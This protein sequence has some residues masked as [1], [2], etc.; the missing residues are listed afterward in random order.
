MEGVGR[1]EYSLQITSCNTVREIGKGSF[2]SV[3]LALHPDGSFMAVKTVK[4]EKVCDNAS[5]EVKDF[6]KE[7]GIM[8]I[9]RHKNIVRYLGSSFVENDNEFVLMIFQEYVTGGSASAL[10]RQLQQQRKLSGNDGGAF[11]YGDF[12]EEVN[13]LPYDPLR[14]FSRHITEGLVYLHS[15]NIAHRDLKGDNVLISYDT[16]IAK[17]AD[18]GAA[19]FLQSTLQATHRQP[20]QRGQATA[21]TFIG[22]PYWMA[23][24][25]IASDGGYDA[26]KADIW[27]LGCTVGE[28]WT[29]VTPWKPQKQL[30]TT[31]F[32][33]AQ[34]SGWPDNIPKHKCPPE[35]KEF[36]DM[37]F[38]RDPASRPSAAQ[39]LDHPFLAVPSA[40]EV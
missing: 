3:S 25:V 5:S 36:L 27:S 30:M 31:V 8:D 29:G 14:V 28:M 9:C 18:F 22:T 1:D 4:V 37:T 7:V 20:G 16:G 2:G 6:V 26:Q 17:L 12:S 13:G 21:K 23:P 15:K 33:I 39:L 35:L 24:E 40:P 38:T 34:S 11:V 10:C 19:H 32:A